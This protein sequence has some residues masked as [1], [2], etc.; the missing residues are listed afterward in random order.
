MLFG[1][2]LLFVILVVAAAG[3][4]TFTSFHQRMRDKLRRHAC[5]D[6]LREIGL[7]CRMWENEHDGQWPKLSD[8]PGEFMFPPSVIEYMGAKMSI[9]SCPV[10]SGESAGDTY[11]GDTYYVYLGPGLATEE[12]ALAFLDDYLQTARTG[13]PFPAPTY[14]PPEDPLERGQIEAAMPLAVH[15][16]GIHQDDFLNVLFVDGHVESVVMAT[17]YPATKIFWDKLSAV[18]AAI[19]EIKAQSTSRATG[20]LPTAD[21]S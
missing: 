13:E 7:V 3:M 2:V 8:V 18:E 14:S 10:E 11:P 6:N 4:W 17:R 1:S 5:W 9:L 12:D 21:H 16:P 15:R 20:G 19:R